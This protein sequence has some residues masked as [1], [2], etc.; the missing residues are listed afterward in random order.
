MVFPLN[1]WLLFG[2]CMLVS[3]IGFKNYPRL[4]QLGGAEH[5]HRIS[6]LSDVGCYH[7]AQSRF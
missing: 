4:G 1:F 5:Q 6:G 7:P 2:L 3:A